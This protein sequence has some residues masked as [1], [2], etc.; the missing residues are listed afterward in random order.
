MYT[1]LSSNQSPREPY[2]MFAHY[3]VETDCGTTAWWTNKAGG[4]RESLNHSLPDRLIF[5]CHPRKEESHGS[6]L[7]LSHTITTAWGHSNKQLIP[8]TVGTRSF[9]CSTHATGMLTTPNLKAKFSMAHYAC[10]HVNTHTSRTW[11]PDSKYGWRMALFVVINTFSFK[12]LMMGN[13]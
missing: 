7:S 2:F 4:Y 10:P 1:S 11:F 9:Q 3:F 12:D 13:T 6:H 8:T 5:L